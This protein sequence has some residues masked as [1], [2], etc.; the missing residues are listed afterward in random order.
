MPPRPPRLEVTAF[1]AHGRAMIRKHPPRGGRDPLANRPV[2]A[3][4]PLSALTFAALALALSTPC[5]A[6][7]QAPEGMVPYDHPVMKNGRLVLWHGISHGGGAPRAAKPSADPAGAGADILVDASDPTEKRTALDL[8][9]ALQ[10][11]HIKGAL[12]Q[13]GVSAAGLDKAIKAQGANFAIVTLPPLLAHEDTAALRAAAPIVARLGAETVEIVAPKRLGGV[14]A[15][16]EAAVDI[17]PEGSPQ[18]ASLG[19]LFDALGLHPKIQHHPLDQALALL[20]AGKLDAVAT[21]GVPTPS[22]LGDFGAKGDFHLLP[23]T[24]RPALRGLFTPATQT[25]AE[26]PH[27]LNAGETLATVGA[28]VA[29][30]VL[31][32]PDATGK[33]TEA[34]YE[35]FAAGG[36]PWN[37]SAWRNVN[38]ACVTAHWP[39]AK[40]V[41]DWLA[42]RGGPPNPGLVA[43]QAGAAQSADDADKVYDQLL[44]WR[45]TAP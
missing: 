28:P 6:A 8:L 13:G 33:A 31:G 20:Q 22:N 18:A 26:R 27:L 23:V 36:A 25:A 43:F 34:L 32:K 40:G 10:A 7:S 42:N 29:L 30:I 1:S 3:L 41:E 39:R 12:V 15:L 9:A 45:R 19:A 24:W 11:A 14:E 16:D 2:G 21:M 17:G 4:K 5:F 35:S 38:F 37:A 44:R